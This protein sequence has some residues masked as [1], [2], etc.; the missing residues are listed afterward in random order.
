MKC[1]TSFVCPYC[2]ESGGE[3]QTVYSREYQGE[4]PH[5]G[6][7]EHVD[8]MCSLCIREQKYREACLENLGYVPTQPLVWDTTSEEPF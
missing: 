3:P 8:E 1:E 2:G 6:M 7:V 5:G 4:S